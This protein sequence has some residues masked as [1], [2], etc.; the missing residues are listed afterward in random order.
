MI[1][2]L[3]SVIVRVLLVGGGYALALVVVGALMSAF[4]VQLGSTRQGVALLP[5]LFASGVLIALLL[6]PLA[7]SLAA[8]RGQQLVVWSCAIFFN[9]ISTLIEG[10]FFAPELIRTNGFALAA[11]QLVL[12]V[13]T[14]TLI[15][16]LFARARGGA[17]APARRSGLQWAWRFVVSALSYLAFYFVFGALNYALVTQPYYESH[18]GGIGVPAPQTV[19]IAEAVRAPLIVLAIVPFILLSARPRRELAVLCGLILFVVGGIVPLLLQANT[20]PAF[21]LIASGVEIFC[22]NFLT[23]VVSA[24]L[25]GRPSVRSPQTQAYAMA[26]TT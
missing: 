26:T 7:A 9:R 1:S 19:L 20:L 3:V 11:Q 12:D 17:A 2:R 5:W 22:Q 15:V 4:G 18:A 14:A 6:G 8:S 25:L 24:R 10:A 23:G 21:L 13:V 16:W